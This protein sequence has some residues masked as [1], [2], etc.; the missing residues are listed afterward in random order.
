M[1]KTLLTTWK[2]LLCGNCCL[3]TAVRKLLCGNCCAEIAVR[4][5]LCGN[6]CAE[7]AVRKHTAVR[8][9][10]RKYRDDVDL[11]YLPNLKI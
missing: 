1:P 10:A 7:T 4:K 2:K 6:F 11:V 3:E 8:E 5:L 9:L